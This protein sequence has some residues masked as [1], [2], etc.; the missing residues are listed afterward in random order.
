MQLK[1]G[2]LLESEEEEPEEEFS[3]Q[4]LGTNLLNASRENRVDDVREWLEKKAD[5][6][7]GEKGWT[8]LLW[9]ACNGN[10]EIVRILI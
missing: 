6:L 5:P 3:A 7:Y 2:D 8:P 1:E 9:A 10:E 4:E